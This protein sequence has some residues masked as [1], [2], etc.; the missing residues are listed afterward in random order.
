LVAEGF[1]SEAQELLLSELA[2]DV[3]EAEAARQR[4]AAADARAGARAISL[5]SLARAARLGIVDPQ[6]YAARL[7]AEGFAE[8]DIAIEMDLLTVAI[9]EEAAARA[10]R[11]ELERQ[12]A[13]RGLSLADVARAVKAGAATIE[14]YRGR[15]AEMGFAPADVELLV[16]VLERELGTIADARARRAELFGADASRALSVSQLEEAVTKGLKS[17]EEFIADVRALGY[18]AD[19]AELLALLIEPPKAAENSGD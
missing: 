11:A 4:Q 12:A 1:T 15:A 19:D 6:A 14:T 2:V 7:T 16:D 18:G 8:E 3:A 5:A 13:A 17:I 10:R 9:A